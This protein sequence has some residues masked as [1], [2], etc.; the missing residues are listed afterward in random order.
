MRTSKVKCRVCEKE[1]SV[2]QEHIGTGKWKLGSN[3]NKYMTTS[4]EGICF[5]MGGPVR[6]WF[7]NS[8]WE[9]IRK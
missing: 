9:L 8:C 6:P 2:K 4:D 5:Y 3:K 1:F 7:C